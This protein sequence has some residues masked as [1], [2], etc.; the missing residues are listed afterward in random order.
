MNFSVL[1]S[2]TYGGTVRYSD[3]NALSHSL[4]ITA[5]RQ[6]GSKWSLTV[7]GAAQD[8]TMAQYL[9]QPTALS[10]LSQLPAT[11]DD[12]AAAFNLGQFSNSQVASMLTGASVLESPARALL[13]GDRVLSYS[14]NIGLNYAYS[15]RLSF[16]FASFSAGGQSRRG[17]KNGVPEQEYILPR[18]LGLNA[19][20]GLSYSV[21]PRTQLGLNVDENRTINK[22]QNAYTTEASG[23]ISRKMGVHWFMG[24]HGGGAMTRMRQGTY[25]LP[26]SN[27]VVGGGFIGW[28][29]YTQTYVGSYNR[30]GSAAYGLAAGVNTTLTGSWSW[31]RPGS[32]WTLNA[33]GG[34]HQIRSAGFASISGWETSGG[35]SG[36][37]NSQTSLSAQYVYFN[38]RGSYGGNLN[39]MIVQS[40]R[41]SLNWN[42]QPVR[43]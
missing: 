37:L 12:L 38:S 20:M 41:V 22:Y 31:R 26:S 2:L 42:P 19:G 15:S 35:I 27:D 3:L 9:F 34:Q 43:H 17:G 7:A 16:H 18:S 5:S 10:V 32:R 14:A 40:I 33:S 30:S 21:T 8:G 36:S 4:S 29:T 1:Y 25:A 13:L 23:S 24:V 11:F 39:N 28:Q 6:L